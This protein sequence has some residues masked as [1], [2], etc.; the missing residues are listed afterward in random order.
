VLIKKHISHFKKCKICNK[1]GVSFFKKNYSDLEFK[2]FFKNFYGYKQSRILLSI[3]DNYKFHILKC[4]NCNFIW[5]EVQ[6]IGKIAFKLYEEIID[7]NKSY[8]K[9]KYL[10]KKIKNKVK[11]EEK[12]MEN[13]FPS[14]KIKVLDFGAGWGNWLDHLDKEKFDLFAFE[15]S[16]TRSIHLKNKGIKI[17][18]FS[19]VRKYE[20]FFDYIRLEQVLEHITEL[21]ECM[22]NLRR[23]TKKNSVINVSVP[24]GAN[25]INNCKIR[26]CKGPIQ[27]LEH[28]NCFSNISLKKLF[29]KHGFVSLKTSELFK[30]SFD[31]FYEIFPKSKFFTKSLLDS[32]FSTSLKFKLK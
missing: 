25:E 22:Q 29:Y 17:L 30:F 12:L 14:K 31:S 27:P 24:N 11:L 6:P 18:N 13:Y 9:N 15:L 19:N 16:K 10:S 7:Q 23:L 5:Q 2:N 20:K 26:V 21:N 8:L 3:L 4:N 1:K 28:V 32:K